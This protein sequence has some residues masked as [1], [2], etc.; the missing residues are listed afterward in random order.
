MFSHKARSAVMLLTLVTLPVAPANACEFLKRCFGGTTAYYAPAPACCPQPC[1]PQP[2]VA[3][4]PQTCYR[5]V[6]ANVPVVAYRPMTACDPCTGCAR[7]VMR[8]VTTYMTQARLVPY[9]SYRPVIT[10]NYAPACAQ[11]ACG[12]GC[13]PAAVAVAAPAPVQTYAAYAPAP[14]PVAPSCCSPSAAPTAVNYPPTNTTYP[15]VTSNYQPA[16]PYAAPGPV[17]TPQPYVAPGTVGAT[18]NSLAPTPAPPYASQGYPAPPSTTAPLTT[19]PETSA[20]ATE[21]PS[22][23]P[24]TTTP[25]VTSPSLGAPTDGTFTPNQTFEPN[26]SQNGTTP[27]PQSRVVQ[28]LQFNPSSA[29]ATSP[30]ALDPETQ[31]RMTSRPVRQAYALKLASSAKAETEPKAETENEDQLWRAGRN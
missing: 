31:D 30:S 11:P 2:T 10:A 22:L 12:G 16:Q 9:T 7:T 27:A 23:S 26:G 25:P 5:T 13:A 21:T 1:A 29:P 20:P 28:P 14:Q 3:Y 15:P 6:Y 17:G 24:S 18:V 4:M 19:T 8:P